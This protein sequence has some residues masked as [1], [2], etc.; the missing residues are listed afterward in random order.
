MTA[1]RK[2][3]TGGSGINN[4]MGMD[5]MVDEVDDLKARY[6]YFDSIANKLKEGAR[7]YPWFQFGS[8]PREWYVRLPVGLDDEPW[9]PTGNP[10]PERHHRFRD[11]LL[12]CFT[13]VPLEAS[14]VQY[15]AWHGG[16]RYI[17]WERGVGPKILD[18]FAEGG[19]FW[20]LSVAMADGKAP[21]D[22]VVRFWCQAFF[23]EE[24]LIEVEGQFWMIRSRHCF[25]RS[26]EYPKPGDKG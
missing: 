4:I 24:P 11:G 22:A 23:P 17:S 19:L 26:T 7:K 14:I 3:R 25:W 13:Q 12:L 16:R 6:P 8:L 15:L 5:E 2:I 10:P 18:D 9:I 20:H 1:G 21:T